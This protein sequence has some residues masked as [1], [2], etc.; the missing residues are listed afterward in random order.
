MKATKGI[1]L[2][3]SI[4]APE[5]GFE[6]INKFMKFN[7]DIC[8]KDFK[9]ALGLAGHKRMHGPSNGSVTPYFRPKC[10]VIE[11]QEEITV[12]FLETYLSRICNCKNCNKRFF[13]VRSEYQYC[14]KS[15]STS[16]QN[17]KRKHDGWSLSKRSKQQISQS[18]KKLPRKE[19][20]KPKIEFS[21]EF[22]RIFNMNCKHCNSKFCSRTQKQYC[23]EHAAL[24]MAENRNR[25][26]FTFNVFHYP[27]LFDLESLD[28]TG[29]Y[30]P[31]GKAGKWNID[32]LSRDHKVSVNESI[33]NN[34]DPFYI[35]HPLNC[36]LI[37]HAANNKK[38]TKSSI[39]Y[40]ELVL[41][42]EDYEQNKHK[43][44]L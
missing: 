29:W 36:E 44:S 30:S 10:C 31:G 6:P 34:Y 12:E 38:K 26:K 7:C 11:T 35:K 33:K 32:G 37:T 20:T 5:V 2:T 28:K 24:Y 18:L 25:F 41:L 23:S 13:A 4:L 1:P 40:E 21:G 8:N 3:Y 15:C 43:K 16:S 9:S 22:S 39:E 19:S 42:V 14:S 17:Q 27:E